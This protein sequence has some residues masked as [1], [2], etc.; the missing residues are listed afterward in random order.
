MKYKVI[1]Y[2]TYGAADVDASGTFNFYT[3]Q[4]ATNCCLSWVEIYGADQALLFNGAS[5]SYV[6]P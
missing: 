1:L 4:A 2:N 3:L 6:N 5:W